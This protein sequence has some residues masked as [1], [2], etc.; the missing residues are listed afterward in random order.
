MVAYPIGVASHLFFFA[1]KIKKIRIHV[2]LLSFS[3]N[4]S[5]FLN[6]KKEENIL[7][8]ASINE[9]FLSYRVAALLKVKFLSQER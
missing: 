7:L 4:D 9:I 1:I 3:M 2:A 5:A 8:C 6:K